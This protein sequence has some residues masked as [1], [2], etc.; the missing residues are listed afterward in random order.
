LALLRA[1]KVVR[2]RQA[3]QRTVLKEL[4][5]NGVTFKLLAGRYGPYVTDGTTNASIPKSG[6]PDALTFAE[7][8]ALLEARRNAAPSARRGAAAGRR[9]SAAPR[10]KKPARK[11]AGA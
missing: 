5:S 1:P 11:V 10:A 2:R 4:T 7:A 8:A 6:N 3:A 9:R